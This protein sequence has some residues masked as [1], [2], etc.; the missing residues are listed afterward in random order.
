MHQEK[1][2]LVSTPVAKWYNFVFVLRWVIFITVSLSSFGK[3]RTAYTIFWIL[4]LFALAFTIVCL[5][6]FMNF[7]GILI[8]VEEFL[9][10]FWHFLTFLF[11]DDAKNKYESGT[12]KF[13]M[14]VTLI[15]YLIIM[16]I[17]IILLFL[18]GKTCF[19]PKKNGS[20]VQQAPKSNR[21]N[22]K[23]PHFK[24]ELP[25]SAKAN[26]NTNGNANAI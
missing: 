19:S 9:L 25:D 10:L 5:K 20:N 18:G 4:D 1:S 13:W 23:E 2:M 12:I 21:T 14:T 16:L 24:V 22:D 11:F 26:L 17:E 8:I 3:P 6:S 15:F 7:A